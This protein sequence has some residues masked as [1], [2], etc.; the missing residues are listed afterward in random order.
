MASHNRLAFQQISQAFNSALFSRRVATR[1]QGTSKCD[2]L[3]LQKTRQLQQW[4]I[5]SGQSRKPAEP[6]AGR[7]GWLSPASPARRGTETQ[8]SRHELRAA[9]KLHKH[10]QTAP[11]TVSEPINTIDPTPAPPVTWMFC[12][13]TPPACPLYSTHL[14]TGRTKHLL[15][16]WALLHPVHKARQD[17]FTQ[18]E[19]INSFLY[20]TLVSDSLAL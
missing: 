20:Q 12:M 4:A 15:E 10:A 13:Q 2:N 3:K 6:S 1:S 8:N 16:A 5:S 18:Q 14:G 9:F 17:K 19:Q 7:A 11:H